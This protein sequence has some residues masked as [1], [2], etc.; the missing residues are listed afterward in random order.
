MKD[1]MGEATRLDLE[2]ALISWA[3]QIPFDLNSFL[4]GFDLELEKKIDSIRV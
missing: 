3:R 4:L 2:D 1:I